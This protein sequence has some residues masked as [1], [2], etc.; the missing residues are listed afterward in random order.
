MSDVR[1]LKVFCTGDDQ[2]RVIEKWGLA[3]DCY[4]IYPGFLVVHVPPETAHE[5]AFDFIYEDLTDQ[6]I[7]K[8]DGKDVQAARDN[9]ELID[10]RPHHFLVQF[11]GPI[12]EQ[13]IRSIRRKGAEF[14]EPFQAFSYVIRCKKT[15][16]KK[17]LD[18]KYVR[19]TGYLPTFHRDKVKVET[20]SA[21]DQGISNNTL[22]VEFFNP[23]DMA[24]GEKAIK[25]IG[26]DNKSEGKSSIAI[27]A[28]RPADGVLTVR[29][30][31]SDNKIEKLAEHISKVHGVRVVRRRVIKKSKNDVASGIMGVDQVR[32]D[33]CD[34][35]G[36]GEIVA[37]CDGGFDI[38][39]CDDVHPDFEGRVIAVKSYPIS[40]EDMWEVYNEWRDFG[41][42]DISDGHGTHVAGSVLGNGACTKNLKGYDKPIRG[43]AY[44]AK[45][46]FQAVEQ[47]MAWRETEYYKE[48]GRFSLAGLS[49]DIS[50]ILGY[51]Y[52]KGARIHSNSW[53][54]G[55]PG[56]YDNTCRLV[57]KFMWEKKDF[58]V[59]VCAGNEGSDKDFRG[60][61]KP[62]SIESP[63][64]AKNC[65]TVGASESLRT[66]FSDRTYGKRWPKDYPVAPFWDSPMANNHYQVVA[67]SSRGPT[68]DG[69][70]KPDI[71]APGTF[72]LSTRSRAIPHDHSGW[73]SIPG[74]L[75]YFYLGGTSMATPLVSGL[76]ALLRQYY[77]ETYEVENPSSALL[78]ATLIGGA[79]KLPNYSPSEQHA[80]NHQG[81]GR[82]N[83]Q[84]V[85]CPKWPTEVYVYDAFNMDNPADQLRTGDFVQFK[86]RIESAA[87]PLRIAMAYTDY[88]GETLVNNLNLL[89]FRSNMS[90]TKK[91]HV[92]YGN[93]STKRTPDATNNTEV[94]HIENP[95]P[96]TWIL[97]LIASNV[98]KGPQDYALFFSGH[99]KDGPEQF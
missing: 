46:V 61:I 85:V 34:L 2:K 4:I 15:Q 24:K 48:Y 76:C 95:E 10:N 23:D 96:G 87:V 68:K 49:E 20:V 54:G 51:A 50:E 22:V 42:A 28:S 67:F 38:G 59:V 66:E 3:K 25:K 97:Q 29:T 44:E 6:F 92:G 43:I 69:R 70:I 7:I 79:L 41:A 73:E 55:T 19:W 26:R 21:D 45:L 27:V 77:K 58:T 81:Y 94:I 90:G 11:K 36:K 60:E 71:V 84:N 89:L 16:L 18:Y 88:P 9:L 39:R 98:P 5:I 53:G 93:S 99:F 75:D 78:K 35:T 64:T 47:E 40:E 80:D 74:N 65:I 1:S 32:E 33:G 91:Y 82:A 72:I 37:V 52:G 57:D 62:T 63:A 8:F 86:F 31:G 14:R 83:I 12:K 56:E 17:I 30:F 13:W